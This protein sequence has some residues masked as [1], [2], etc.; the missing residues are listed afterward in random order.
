MKPT[1]ATLL[2][3]VLTVLKRKHGRDI[4]LILSFF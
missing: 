4:S 2:L 3:D 1:L